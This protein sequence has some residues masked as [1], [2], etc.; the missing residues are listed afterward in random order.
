MSIP[1]RHSGRIAF[2]ALI[3]ITL[4]ATLLGVRSVVLAEGPAATI[5]AGPLDCFV[6]GDSEVIRRSNSCRQ[7]RPV[8]VSRPAKVH[9]PNQE[10]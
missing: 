4:I 5:D 6:I 1:V 7:D 2:A 9:Q 8:S 10:E 3:V